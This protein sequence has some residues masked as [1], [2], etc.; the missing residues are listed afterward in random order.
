MI[1]NSSRYGLRNIAFTE[2][3]GRNMLD[4]MNGRTI[5]DYDDYAISGTTNS[6]NNV[7]I[8][9]DLPT[10][11]V[12][13]TTKKDKIIKN[14]L[15]GAGAIIAALAAWKLGAFAKLGKLISKIP[16]TGKLTGFVKALSP[17]NF[18]PDNIKNKFKNFKIKNFSFKSI[19]NI[20]K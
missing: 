13:L 14:S 11:K 3:I 2:D 18:I 20:F 7:N 19:K 8:Y 9:K 16:G 10:D 6:L 17:K 4:K 12:E 1:D 5:E 15:Y